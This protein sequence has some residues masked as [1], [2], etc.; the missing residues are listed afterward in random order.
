MLNAITVNNRAIT[1]GPKKRKWS[2]H[3]LKSISPL[4]DNQRVMMRSF[5][6]GSHICAH[7]SAGTGK[8]YLALYLALSEIFN[9]ETDP[10]K[11]II[12]RS[13]VPTRD[14]GF[15][16]G[17]LDE[18][19]AMY[20]LPYSDILHDLLGRPSSYADM[21]EAGLIHFTTTSFIRGLTWDNAVVVVDECQNM[22]AHEINGIMTRVGKGT[23]VIFCGDLVQSD[24]RD[25]KKEQTG[26]VKFLDIVQTLSDFEDIS[27][28]Y[29]DIVRSDFVKRWIMSSEGFV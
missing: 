24:L 29:Y 10:V 8:S 28:T 27:F 1:E 5:F 15:L 22:T 3:D 9:P 4:T 2:R 13:V 11:L 16:P 21:K 18:K 14:V 25:S 12:V 23:R 26:M 20:E 19:T 17:T 6:E 7:G